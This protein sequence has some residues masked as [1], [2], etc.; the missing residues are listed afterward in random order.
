MA[1]SSTSTVPPHTIGWIYDSTTSQTI[2][3][4][5]RPIKP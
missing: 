1:L 3:Y 4:V 2:V 5:V